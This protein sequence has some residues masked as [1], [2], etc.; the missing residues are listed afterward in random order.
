MKLP[1]R[2]VFVCFITLVISV[3]LVVNYFQT[4]LPTGEVILIADRIILSIFISL[5][6]LFL[7]FYFAKKEERKEVPIPIKELEKMMYIVSDIERSR[8]SEKSKAKQLVK[9]LLPYIQTILENYPDFVRD[10]PSE[11]RRVFSDVYTSVLGKH[12]RYFERRMIKDARHLKEAV[13]E[14]LKKY[15]L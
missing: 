1:F 3:L 12:G 15:K 4:T 13:S 11:H 10:L 7:V 2:L 5:F 14:I 9:G 8:L 6:L